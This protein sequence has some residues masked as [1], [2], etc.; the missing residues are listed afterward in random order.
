MH[1]LKSRKKST[2]STVLCVLLLWK[3]ATRRP[4]W[5]SNLL[6]IRTSLVG[7]MG[8]GFCSGV[9]NADP[10]WYL[11]AKLQPQGFA[12]CGKKFD[13]MGDFIDFC[14]IYI[15][16]LGWL[17]NRSSHQTFPPQV[18]NPWDCNFAKSIG[19]G[20][21]FSPPSRILSPCRPRGK[22]V[23]ISI[24]K[25]KGPANYLVKLICR[26]QGHNIR[27]RANCSFEPLTLGRWKLH[28]FAYARGT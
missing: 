26:C 6:C 1:S 17:P 25:P 24:S 18:A 5:A 2:N 28:W 16:R 8:S 19:R 23:Y 11:F 3:N 20:L 9:K 22:F 12:T 13:M 4:C 14:S 21:H 10:S 27:K 7:G 15:T